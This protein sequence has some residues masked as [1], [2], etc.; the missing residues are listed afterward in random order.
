MSLN[1]ILLIIH[2]LSIGFTN[3]DL[4]S[5]DMY[6]KIENTIPC[7]RRANATYQIG[8]GNLDKSDYDGVVYMIRNQ[9][10]LNTLKQLELKSTK[11]LIAV[12]IPE[13]FQAVV[14]F[15]LN[16]KKEILNGLVLISS[17]NDE[18]NV[19]YSKLMYSDDKLNP[20]TQFS[21]YFDKPGYSNQIWNKAGSAFMFQNFKIPFYLLT[22]TEESQK[23]VNCYEKFNSHI[24]SSQTLA[25]SNN[26]LA[27]KSMDKL[28]GMQLGLQ[29]FQ[30]SSSKVC[31]RR[32]TIQH[33]LESSSFCDP[34][35]GTHYF[36]YSSMRPSLKL[37][38]ILLTSRIDSFTL[39]EYFTPAANQPITSI[40]GLLAIADLLSNYKNEFTTKDILFMFLDNEAFDYAGSSRLV[41]DLKLN[42]FPDLIASGGS[43]LITNSD[44]IDSIIEISQMGYVSLNNSNNLWIHRDPITYKD[45]K[46]KEIVDNMTNLFAQYSNNIKLVSNSSQPLLPSSFQ[47]FLKN[48]INLPGIVLADH[49]IEYTNK[50]YHSIFDTPNKLNYSFNGTERDATSLNS[51]L[52]QSIQTLSTSIA[53]VV[54]YLA[55]G[56][57]P[58]DKTSLE[59]INRLLYCYYVNPECGLF[60]SVLKPDA[61]KAFS[62]LLDQSNPKNKL[63]FYTGVNNSTISGKYITN[64]VLKYLTRNKNM[65]NLTYDNCTLDN[66]R[67]FSNPFEINSVDFI[68]LGSTNTNTL[69]NGSRCI[70]TSVYQRTSVSPALILSDSGLLQ[71]TDKYSAWTESQWESK[72]IQMKLFL[73]PTMMMETLTIIMGVFVFLSSILLTY[74][75]NKYSSKWLVTSEIIVHNENF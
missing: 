60:Q 44:L 13:I 7:V 15:H 40:I 34:M 42:L 75:M 9:T 5:D 59:L 30:S 69:Y 29:M 24:F 25:S 35:G 52:A 37:P 28:C 11:R 58:T 74:F 16:D 21:Y 45:P 22:S 63:C 46:I 18:S 19:D 55:T 56:K 70:A 73:Y 36:A 54:F 3:G 67:K 20:N 49:E 4:I 32:N 65:D 2:V 31:L 38:Q 12:T 68:D 48:N 47:T 66:V 64:A 8:C 10:E 27:F 61:F 53:N 17:I 1:L 23:I 71:H 50:F 43:K 33:V 62:N 72:N 6:T 41:H 51:Q 57:N 39:Y 26:V 14:D